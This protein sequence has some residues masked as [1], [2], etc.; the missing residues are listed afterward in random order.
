M[1]LYDTPAGTPNISRSLACTWAD[2]ALLIEQLP[3]LLPVKPGIGRHRLDSH[4]RDLPA[5]RIRFR[6]L[7][8]KP[9][10]KSKPFA[11]VRKAL[12]VSVEIGNVY[13]LVPGRVEIPA[14]SRHRGLRRAELSA[15]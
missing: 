14:P 1:F 9:H 10:P 7:E 6:R 15:V 3:Y 13:E 4:S 5:P 2:G 12:E 11:S 8:V